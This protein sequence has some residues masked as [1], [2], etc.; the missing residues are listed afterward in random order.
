MQIIII[1]INS[2]YEILINIVYLFDD[3]GDGDDVVLM[4]FS[5]WG[6]CLLCG[7]KQR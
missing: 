3:H 5:L 4:N 7:V 6:I 1:I 2:D